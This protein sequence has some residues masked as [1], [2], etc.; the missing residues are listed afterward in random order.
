[1]LITA[2]G[3]WRF[4]CKFAATTLKFLV[5]FLRLVANLFAIKLASVLETDCKVTSR[6]VA[7]F[8]F[9][10]IIIPTNIPI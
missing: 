8:N 1:M 3:P 6:N 2:N 7:V 4:L 9:P 5:F 10:F